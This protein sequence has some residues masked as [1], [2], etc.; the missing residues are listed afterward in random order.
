MQERGQEAHQCFWVAAKMGETSLKSAVRET[1][2]QTTLCSVWPEGH[3]KGNQLI[4]AGAGDGARDTSLCTVDPQLTQQ[5]LEEQSTFIS[6]T[7][8]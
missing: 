1:E 4:R 7:D 6:L 5:A 2:K 8:T 3:R